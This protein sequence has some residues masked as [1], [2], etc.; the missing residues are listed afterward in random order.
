VL[1]PGSIIGRGAVIYPG[2]N[3][4]GVLPANMIAKN[5]AEIEVAVLR[6]REK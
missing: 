5:R 2:V 3:W 4:R 1:N 6:P